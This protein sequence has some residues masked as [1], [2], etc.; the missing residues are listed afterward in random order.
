VRANGLD[1][2][3]NARGYESGNVVPCCDPCNRMKGTLSREAFLEHVALVAAWG[4]TVRHV[5]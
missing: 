2:V 1:R 5:E 4:S 3:D